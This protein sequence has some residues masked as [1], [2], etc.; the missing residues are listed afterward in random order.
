MD[1]VTVWNN[2]IGSISVNTGVVHLYLPNKFLTSDNY[3]YF[4]N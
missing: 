2:L 1:D 4:S 3:N